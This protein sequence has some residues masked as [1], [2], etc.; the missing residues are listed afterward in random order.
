M[1]GERLGGQQ[2]REQIS[3]IA[4]TLVDAVELGRV[5]VTV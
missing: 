4:T 3:R 1:A 5:T 2:W